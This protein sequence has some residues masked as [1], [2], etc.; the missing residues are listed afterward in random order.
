MAAQIPVRFDYIHF[1]SL[2]K[3]KYVT[4]SINVLLAAKKKPGQ[5]HE[6]SNEA[7]QLSAVEIG[8]SGDEPAGL[9]ATLTLDR[10]EAN[11]I[12]DNV[13]QDCE[14]VSGIAGTGPHLVV[15]KDH[16]HAPMQAVLDRPM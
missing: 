11:E 13:F 16:I 14:I 9:D 1:D 10:I 15:T 6:G 4:Q 2:P 3:R 8:S 12:E 5:S 7:E